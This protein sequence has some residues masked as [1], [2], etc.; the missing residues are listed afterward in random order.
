M[1]SSTP[2]S[3]KTFSPPLFFSGIF[4]NIQPPD[5]I[6]KYIHPGD[7]PGQ[8]LF[9][10]ISNVIKLI[11]VI[12]GLL[13]I[14]QLITAGYAFISANADAKKIEAAWSKIWQSLVGLLIISSAFA[15]AGLIERFT[16]LQIINP[17]IHGPQ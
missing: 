8:G 17:V 3:K 16:G 12:A 10:L 15:L 11:S 1:T 2:I 6:K 14:L 7:D 4:G 13:L 9:T 5:A